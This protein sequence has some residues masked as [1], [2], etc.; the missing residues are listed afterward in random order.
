MPEIDYPD[1]NLVL[2]YKALRAGP[3]MLVED[4]ILTI[5]SV[6]IVNVKF[7][8][9]QLARYAG[10]K[11]QWWVSLAYHDGEHI[12]IYNGIT[13]GIMVK[14]RKKISYGFNRFFKPDQHQKTLAEMLGDIPQDELDFANHSQY[15]KVSS[16][17]KAARLFMKSDPTEILDVMDLPEWQGEYQK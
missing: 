3:Y 4:T 14:P 6:H 10:S 5:N 2:A 11:A 15:M 7:V 17:G 9:E 1:G 8:T 16:R 12:Y 13:D